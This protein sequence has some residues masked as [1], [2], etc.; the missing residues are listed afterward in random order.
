TPVIDDA[1]GLFDAYAQMAIG[2]VDHAVQRGVLLAPVSVLGQRE[3]TPDEVN[4]NPYVLHTI[5]SIDARTG[6]ST[7]EIFRVCGVQPHTRISN[8]CAALQAA[9]AMQ[10]LTPILMTPSLS[11]P[12]LE[13]GRAARLA[14]DSFT[15]QQQE[16]INRMGI[17]HEDLART[18]QSY[19]Y[20]L[21]RIGSCGAGIWTE[22]A[23]DSVEAYLQEGHSKLAA[24]EINTID[25]LR[26]PHT[27]RIRAVLD[28]SPESTTFEGCSYD[29]FGGNLLAISDNHAFYSAIFTALEN[30]AIHGENVVELTARQ[31]GL[32][33]LTRSERLHA[34]HRAALQASR[35]GNDSIVYGKKPGQWV[36][37]SL[38][39]LADN[40]PFIHINIDKRLRLLGNFATMDETVLALRN[41]C[42]ERHTAIPSL[43]AYYDLGLNN[44]A[45]YMMAQRQALWGTKSQDRVQQ[46]ELHTAKAFHAQVGRL[47]LI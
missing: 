21:R 40:A 32:G 22:P 3:P 7:A 35:Y 15:P 28:G 31:L 5:A 38:L 26:G 39:E 36:A 2:L 30:K 29:T 25:R 13:G 20:L 34:A 43:E 24:G 42:A 10:L 14:Y 17:T 23:P 9:E 45:V 4:T 37:D 27:D 16:H 18:Y 1:E 19:R 6:F 47:A 11:G 41:W 46:I 12:F 8:L 44:A 33:H